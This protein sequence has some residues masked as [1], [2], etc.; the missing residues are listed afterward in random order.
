MPFQDEDEV[1]TPDP[2]PAPNR[3]EKLL[4]RVFIEDWSLKLLSLGIAVI[5]WL[6]GYPDRAGAGAQDCL[7]LAQQ[8]GH[9]NSLALA[10]EYASLAPIPPRARG[11]EGTRSYTD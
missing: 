1:T 7:E 5:L 6:L 9:P 10:L 11:S 4:R 8:L 3:A 2:R